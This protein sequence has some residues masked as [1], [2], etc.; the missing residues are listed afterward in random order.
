MAKLYGVFLLSLVG[1]TAIAQELNV[2][3]FN[4]RL[5]TAADRQYE[6]MALS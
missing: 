6:C 5:N 2:M 4:I 3:T 1:S